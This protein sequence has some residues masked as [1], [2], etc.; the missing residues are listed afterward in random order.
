[1][2]S[3]TEEVPERGCRMV[4]KHDKKVRGVA[5]TWPRGGAMGGFAHKLLLSMANHLA[6]A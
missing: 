3:Y 1:M 5:L 6:C 4:Q 2:D